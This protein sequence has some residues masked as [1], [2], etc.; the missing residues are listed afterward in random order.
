MGLGA[1]GPDAAKGGLSLDAQV[2]LF[3]LF[4]AVLMTA[5]GF[6]QKLNGTRGGGLLLSGWVVVAT[7]CYLPTFFIGNLVFSW[8]GRISV[9]V[10]MSAATYV[11]TLVVARLYFREAVGLGQVAGCLLVV[12]GV[13]LIAR[14]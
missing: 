4:N 6:F 9:F 14:G 11:L 12:A 1:A 10:P 13:A 5:G 2:A 7:L 3:G 8:G